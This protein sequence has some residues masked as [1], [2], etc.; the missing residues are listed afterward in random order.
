MDDLKVGS[1]VNIE[2]YGIKGDCIKEV[3]FKDIDGDFWVESDRDYD[4]WFTSGLEFLD[5]DDRWATEEFKAVID[6]DKY[7]LCLEYEMYTILPRVKDTELSRFIHENNIFK[8]EDGYLYTNRTIAE[9]NGTS[10]H[11]WA[12][13]ERWILVHDQSHELYNLGHLFEAAVAYYEATGKRAL[14]TPL[15]RA[16]VACGADG[17]LIEV[18]PNPQEALSDG[19]QQLLPDDFDQLIK[20]IRSVAAAIKREL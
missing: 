6:V 3:I 19:P 20:D 7:Y 11:Q 5:F 2:G 8:E 17:L 9:I 18:H 4:D 12:G 15:S 13:N 10:P 14:I 16:A 1:V